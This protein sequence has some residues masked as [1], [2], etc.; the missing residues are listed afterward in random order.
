MA[1]KRVLI[2]GATGILGKAL[3]ESC[4]KDI[5]VFATYFRDCWGKE[6]L[7][8]AIRLNIED[9]NDV[10]RVV[11]EWAR[12]D[13]VIHAAGMSNVDYTENNRSLA[14]SINIDGTINVINAC[15]HNKS[16][17]IYLSTNAVFEGNHPPYTE[18]SERIPVNHYGLLKVKAEDLVINSGLNYSIVR[19]ILMYGWHFSNGRLNPV[20]NWIRM[21]S[22]GKTIQVVNDRY[23]QPLLA[24]D[25]AKLIWKI[26][27]DNKAGIYHVSGADRVTLF[28]FANM[29]AEIFGFDKKLIKP[30]SSSSFPEIA[31]RPVDTSFSINKIKQELNIYP[32]GIKEGLEN[33]KVVMYKQRS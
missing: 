7:C 9:N 2:T 30:V 13:V 24:D 25:C 27:S 5:Q 23:S 26:I 8:P 10:M 4:P 18:E 6:L 1:V 32:V 22:E 11:T 12:P 20:T 15:R 17:L 29:T 14:R 19:A 31:P 28:D 21:L 33:M 16:K 3:I